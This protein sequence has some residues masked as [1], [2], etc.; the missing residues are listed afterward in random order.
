ME[1]VGEGGC[2]VVIVMVDEDE[3][4]NGVLLYMEGEGSCVVIET[5]GSCIVVFQV[6]VMEG[7]SEGEAENGVLL[8]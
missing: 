1:G 3:G 4:E 6:I 7:E 2:A 5:E 8:L